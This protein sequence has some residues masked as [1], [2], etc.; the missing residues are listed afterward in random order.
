MIIL[1]LNDIVSL[2][3]VCQLFEIPDYLS[4]LDLFV[5]SI[6]CPILLRIYRS[7]QI[8]SIGAV[9]CYFVNFIVSPHEVCPLFG[10]PFD[11]TIINLLGSLGLEKVII[12]RVICYQLGLIEMFFVSVSFKII[13]RIDLSECLDM[14]YSA[15]SVVTS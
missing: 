6:W 11:R 1:Q 3:E 13:V 12:R 2:R 8:F 9:I 10:I 5:G 14:F 15:L 4:I 7:I